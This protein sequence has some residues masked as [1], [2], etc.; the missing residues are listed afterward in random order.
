MKSQ[1]VKK[2]LETG[3]RLEQQ[4]HCPRE[5]YTDRL[6]CLS[7]KTVGAGSI[8]ESRIPVVEYNFSHLDYSYE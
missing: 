4:M 7:L 6:L 1:E 2:F 5:L 3:G 8:P